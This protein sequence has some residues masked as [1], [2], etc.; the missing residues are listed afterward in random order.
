MFMHQIFGFIFKFAELLM[1]SKL[2]IPIS[3]PAPSYPSPS[4]SPSQIHLV[5]WVSYAAQVRN[6]VVTKE[7]R[8]M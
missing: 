2:L 3:H 7:R 1:L 6:C 8:L 4:P 5:G